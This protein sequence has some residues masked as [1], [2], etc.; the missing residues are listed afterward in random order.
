MMDVN[1]WG[2]IYPTYYALPHLK[3]SRG[4]LVVC[5]S[6]AGTV[7]SSR[8]SLYNATKAAQI[9]FYETLRSELGSDVGVTIL[10]PGY[11]V[12]EITQGKA[13]QKDGEL[14]VNEETRD[15]R[16]R[17]GPVETLCEIALDNIRKGD[18]YRPLKLIA[19]LAPEVLQRIIEA[20]G[21]RC[22]YPAALRSGNSGVHSSS[23]RNNTMGKM[24]LQLCTRVYHT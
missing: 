3:A 23:R 1:F 4:K 15:V 17:T 24:Q 12:S 14:A 20:T 9:R 16:S 8:M 13:I 7:A 5:S 22:L 2:S 11:V 18:R 21:A 6:V 19:C 10:T